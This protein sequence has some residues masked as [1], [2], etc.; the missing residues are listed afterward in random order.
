VISNRDTDSMRFLDEWL[1]FQDTDSVLPLFEK[2]NKAYDVPKL[3]STNWVNHSELVVAVVRDKDFANLQ[4]MTLPE[5]S[6]ILGLFNDHGEKKMLLDTFSH[7]LASEESSSLLLN[8]AHVASSLLDFLPNAV[9][10]IPSFLQS[11]T[12]TTHKASLEDNLIHLAFT[13][14]K[15]LILSEEEMGTFIRRPIQILLKELK[16]I[17]LREFAEIVELASLTVRSSDSA[18]DL[19]LG[20]LEPETSRL[21]VDRPTVIRHFTSSLFGIALDHIDEASNGRNSESQEFLELGL[22]GRSDGYALVKS[23]LRVDSSLNGMLKA[24]DH[25]RFTASGLPRNAVVARPVSMDAVVSSAEPGNVL[26]RCFHHPPSYLHECAWRVTQCGSFV[27]SKTSFDAVT[28]FYT[29]REACSVIYP[30]LLGLPPVKERRLVGMELQATVDASL[31]ESQN[32]ALVA[33]MKHSLTFV[34]GPPGTGKTH[35]IVVIIAQLLEKLPESRFLVTAPTHNAVDNLL[36]R[37]V[38]YSGPEKSNT[39]PVRVSTQVSACHH[40][41][42]LPLS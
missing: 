42:V 29:E 18:L 12:W 34:W 2:P 21:L 10:L 33:S 1:N 41:V 24:G 27:T 17:S 7:I 19:F 28:A 23:V 14:L 20:V 31:N 15:N 26:F 22:E 40:F 3:S 16:S 30:M 25:V 11:Q 35:T 38:S 36:R 9:Y 13:L 39:I 5:L 6:T 32:A 37:F 8:R 4:N